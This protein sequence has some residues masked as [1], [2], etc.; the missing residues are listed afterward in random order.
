MTAIAKFALWGA[1]GT[2]VF[3]GG[4]T[5]GHFLR[6]AYDVS[7]TSTGEDN[8]RSRHTGSRGEQVNN[9]S[10]NVVHNSQGESQGHS[11]K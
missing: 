8:G 2:L 10:E 5:G 6:E 4:A 3:G 9:T 1:G 11:H 7:A